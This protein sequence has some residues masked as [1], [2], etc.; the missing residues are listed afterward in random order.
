MNDLNK[1]LA[2]DLYKME[3]VSDKQMLEL[4]E[5]ALTVSN[6]N[7]V[8]I[9][10][11]LA[12]YDEVI[13]VRLKEDLKAFQFIQRFEQANES[14]I[15]LGPLF[16]KATFHIPLF[17]TYFKRLLT[18]ANKGFHLLAEVQNPSILLTYK[19]LFGEEMF[20]KLDD[21]PIPEGVQKV[22]SQFAKR[23]FHLNNIEYHSLTSKGQVS[24]LYEENRKKNEVYEWLKRRGVLLENGDSQLLVLS[25]DHTEEAK[26]RMRKQL[27]A[28]EERIENWKVEKEKMLRRFKEA[29]S[30]G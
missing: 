3:H 22:V 17:I 19:V 25:V 8:Y 4:V 1:K 11:R 14:F 20:P 5:L 29:S 18:V 12:I 21:T 28:G 24:S 15:Y 10:Q 6:I 26:D 9:K 30:I 23:I 2:W 16:A 7:E 27:T 13:V